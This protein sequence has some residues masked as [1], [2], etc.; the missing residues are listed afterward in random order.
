MT[1][2]PDHLERFLGPIE[3]GVRGDDSTPNGVQVVHFG[4]GAPFAGVT[5]SATLGL[6]NHHLGQGGLHQ[7]LLMHVPTTRQPGNLAGVLFQVAAELLGRGRGLG[8][9]EVLGPRGVL[10]PD[11]G[12]TALVAAAPVYLPDDFA[13]CD[14]PAA[15]VVL[16]WLI[17][18]TDAEARFATEHGWP[19]L[20]DLFVQQ[21]PDLTDLARASVVL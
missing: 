6:S 21:N 11:T 14:T 4:D 13:V 5:T 20:E 10:F 8:R 2:L 16:T 17:P 18:L 19:A 7:E 3:A 1:D 9:G 12:M 15:P